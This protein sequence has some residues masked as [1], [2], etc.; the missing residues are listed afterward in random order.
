MKDKIFIFVIGLLLGAV[1]ST[2]SIYFY[3]VAANSNNSTQ[4]TQMNG[5]GQPSEMGN[6]QEPPEKP[7]DSQNTTQ[8]NQ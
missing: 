8:S 7:E 4:N 2:A 6:G 3:T 5:G 1:I